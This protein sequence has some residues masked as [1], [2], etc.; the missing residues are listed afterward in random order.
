MGTH[1]LCLHINHSP[2]TVAK[3]LSSFERNHMACKGQNVTKCLALYRKLPVPS[4]KPCAALVPEWEALHFNSDLFAPGIFF[5]VKGLLFVE[6]ILFIEHSLLK[7]LYSWLL[8]SI[9]FKCTG[10]L[11]VY[12]FFLAM[13]WGLGDLS[14]LIWDGTGV[15]TVKTLDSNHWATRKF[16]AQVYLNMEFFQ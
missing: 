16:P 10:L 14:S 13:P 15:M 2:A 3:W 7:K 5:N 8:E 12:L 11:F 9:G 1:P 4:L 6:V